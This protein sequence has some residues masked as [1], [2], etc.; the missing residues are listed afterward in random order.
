MK[1]KEKDLKEVSREMF[2]AGEQSLTIISTGA[3]QRTADA[4]E[5]MTG[6]LKEILKAQKDLKT[7]KDEVKFWKGKATKLEKETEVLRG[8]IERQKKKQK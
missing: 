4:T 3:L 8:A 6:L 1:E 5:E 7:Q 2:R